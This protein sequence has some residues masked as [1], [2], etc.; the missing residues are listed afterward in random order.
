MEHK[1]GAARK[2]WRDPDS[3]NTQLSFM[4]SSN[5]T[6]DYISLFRKN[7]I[8]RTQTYTISKWNEPATSFVDAS[9]GTA[10]TIPSYGYNP[11]EVTK[12][13]SALERSAFNTEQ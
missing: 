9:T 13:S 4:S 7:G 8:N 11:S 3:L 2:H 5:S 10:P 6:E 12:T 1:L